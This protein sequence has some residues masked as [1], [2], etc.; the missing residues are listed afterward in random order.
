MYRDDQ[1]Q[2]P[3]VNSSIKKKTIDPNQKVT[4]KIFIMKSKDVFLKK[5]LLGIGWKQSKSK[6]T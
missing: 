5:I 3:A 2:L 6:R 4:N 1:Q